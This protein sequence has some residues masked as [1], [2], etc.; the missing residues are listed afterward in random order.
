LFDANSNAVIGVI[1][2]ST[3][4]NLDEGPDYD[5]QLNRPCVIRAGGPMMERNTSYTAQV[6]GIA[7][8]FDTVNTLDLERPGCP[9]ESGF[10]LTVQSGDTEVR[11]VL[12]GT[13]ATWGAAL[14]GNHP[15]YAYKRFRAGEDE[16]GSPAGYSPP[17]PLANAPVISD[18]IGREDGYYFLCVIAGNTPS[19]DS[20]WQQ[21]EHASIRFK[22][23]DSQPPLVSIDYHL[24]P[25]LNGYRLVLVTGGE[26]PNGLG[27]S[28]TKRGPLSAVDCYDPQG[29]RLQLSI[30][31]IVRDSDQP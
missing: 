3:I 2:T 31:D 19:F 21:P 20:S 11:P 4:L 25:L 9:L 22:R 23:L 28:L 18:P 29:Y 13:P 24:E 17:I 1:S 15:Y 30:P 26:A 8:C 27:L 6:Q 14:S 10:Q 7:R 12:G 16:C 5:C